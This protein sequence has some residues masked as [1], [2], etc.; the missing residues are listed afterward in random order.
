MNWAVADDPGGGRPQFEDLKQKLTIQS[1]TIQ[2]NQELESGGGGDEA[3]VQENQVQVNLRAHE[4]ARALVRLIQCR[5]CSRPF[6]KPVTMPCGHTV[7]HRCMSAEFM[8]TNITYPGFEDRRRRIRCLIDN[9]GIEH[10]A[11]DC[12]IDFTLA[13]L[14]A[15]IRYDMSMARRFSNAADMLV[16]IVTTSPTSS[17]PENGACSELYRRKGGYLC[18]TFELAEEGKLGISSNLLYESCSVGD[19]SKE[20]DEMLLSNIRE[21]TQ[22]DLICYT[23]HDV[24]A[25]PVTVSCGHTWCRECFTRFL[26][27]RMPC[28]L[29]RRSLQAQRASYSAAGNQCLNAIVN[30]LCAEEIAKR[31]VIPAFISHREFDIPIF[32]CTLSFPGMPT[33]LHIFEERY[34]TMVRRAMEG[35]RQF[36]MVMYNRTGQH[37]DNLGSVSFMEYGTILE[38]LNIEYTP[39][40]R[41]Y[42]ETRG[43]GRFRLRSY[44]HRDEYIIGNAERIDDISIAQ[45]EQF[46]RN[47][48]DNIAAQTTASTTPAPTTDPSLDFS[49]DPSSLPTSELLRRAI[50]FIQHM[51][52]LSADWLSQRIVDA[53]G[54]P[55]EDPAYFPYWFACV[56]PVRDEDK[57]ILLRETSVRERLKI[58]FLWIRVWKSQRWW[59][60]LNSL[61]CVPNSATSPPPFPPPFY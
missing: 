1:S 32:V 23:C 18:A 31:V 44:E 19:N 56:L 41:S 37:Q 21:H 57:Y 45:E 53:Y 40:G 43:V 4:D 35:N 25:D 58:V 33:F 36:G 29:C 24:V 15:T 3:D 51:R 30:A 28:P 38:I 46:E 10:A 34:R 16:R 14:M 61:P 42:I 12:G 13:K 17:T 52:H 11:V 60:F 20:L 49:I 2:S 26:D 48:L 54:G 55:P 7:C 6:D 8:S 5:R 39:D 9:C 59:V 50:M 47:E 27:C 22:G